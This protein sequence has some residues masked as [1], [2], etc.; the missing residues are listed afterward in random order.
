MVLAGCASAPVVT[1]T[2]GS[3]PGYV[4]NDYRRGDP[5]LQEALALG[6]A[7]VEADVFLVAGE[8]LLGHD[9]KEVRPDRTLRGVYL[10][11]LRL[12]AAGRAA[13]RPD[14]QPFLLNV[15]LKQDDPA[16]F[17]A[18]HALLLE[19]RDVLVTVED[20]RVRDGAVQVVLVGW[21]PP[22]AE[23]AALPVRCCAVQR[24]W[25][26]LPPDHAA[27]PA[28]LL[29]LVTVQYPQ[30]FAW[31]GKGPVPPEFARRLAE[32][33]AAR[34]AVPGR[35]LRVFKV[36]QRA[37][38]YEAL[39]AGGVDLIGTKKPAASAPLLAVAAGR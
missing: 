36:P 13:I 33:R 37:A 4:H 17:A 21:Q 25:R 24:Y 10:E 20:G 22:L 14:G 31:D 8:L 39:I 1:R 3:L 5:P 15:E 32:L 6:Y 35:W 26:D 29:K 12:A 38:V 16:A 28:H 18:L 2:P 30:H 9:R 23:L 11:P 34:D 19:Y 7:G 27:L